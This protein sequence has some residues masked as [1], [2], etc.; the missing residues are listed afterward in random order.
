LVRLLFSCVLT[1]LLL[2][3]CGKDSPTP[4]PT[5]APVVIGQDTVL[6]AIGTQNPVPATNAYP[7][8]RWITL[9][10]GTTQLSVYEAPGGV[11]WV[12]TFT[13][14]GASL[15]VVEALRREAESK[16]LRTITIPTGAAGAGGFTLHGDIE[17]LI[18][19]QSFD[20]TTQTIFIALTKLPR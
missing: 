10:P 18:Q 19:V 7:F 3:A 5:I 15:A 1:A 13:L 12:G 16:G 8:S 4:S 20:A 14:P 17:G 9:P 6:P 11:T 2:T